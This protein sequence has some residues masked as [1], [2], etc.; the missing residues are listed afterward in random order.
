MYS[1]VPFPRW[2]CNGSNFTLRLRPSTNGSDSEAEDGSR[3]VRSSKGLGASVTL[4]K[5]LCDKW[6][7]IR[8]G[9]ACGYVHRGI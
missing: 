3:G 8:C 7:W 6:S 2:D 4:S 9:Y 5:D 1:P